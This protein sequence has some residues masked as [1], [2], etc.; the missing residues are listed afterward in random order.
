MEK[1]RER[2]REYYRIIWDSDEEGI[3]LYVYESYGDLSL[4]PNSSAEIVTWTCC[5]VCFWDP[6]IKKDIKKTKDKDKWNSERGKNNN[7]YHK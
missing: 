2:E 7:R 6:K 1:F 5:A 3:S 4:A